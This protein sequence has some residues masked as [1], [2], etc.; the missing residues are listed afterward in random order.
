MV[1]KPGDYRFIGF[2][3]DGIRSDLIH[4]WIYLHHRITIIPK[5]EVPHRHR[6]TYPAQPTTH[7]GGQVEIHIPIWLGTSKVDILKI[8]LIM[9]SSTAKKKE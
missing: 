3:D 7:S 1:E 4:G 9:Y 2:I 5:N 6:E 8:Y